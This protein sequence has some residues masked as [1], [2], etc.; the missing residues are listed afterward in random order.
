MKIIRIAL[1][2]VIVVLA[3][4]IYKGINE[5]IQFNKEK[6]Y[7]YSFVIQKLKDLRTAQIAYKSVNGSYTDNYDSL[8]NFVKNGEFLLIKQIGNPDDSTAVII[9]D[10]IY[11]IV[12]DSLFPKSYEIDSLP[13][14]PFTNGKSKFKMSAGEVEKGKVKVKVFE[15]VD[16]EPFDPTEVLKV[17]SMT[18]PSNAGNWE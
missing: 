7:R 16:T 15:I 1:G 18:E 12:R 13:F 9:R 10:S 8:L 17:G 11:I 3:F 5:P 4:L 6:A 2:G 14:V